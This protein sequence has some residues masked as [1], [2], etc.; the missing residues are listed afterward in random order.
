MAT[1]E[2][3]ESSEILATREAM[4]LAGWRFAVDGIPGAYVPVQGT[5]CVNQPS[6]WII[7]VKAVLESLRDFCE[8]GQVEEIRKE[9]G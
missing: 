5:T 1:N 6:D 3:H 4:R 8:P 2:Q 7:D 9:L